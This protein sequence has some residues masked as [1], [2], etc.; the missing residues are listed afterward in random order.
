[1]FY[2]VNSVVT[3][4]VKVCT[5]LE[6]ACR[7]TRALEIGTPFRGRVKVV[8]ISDGRDILDSFVTRNRAAGV[9]SLI[10]TTVINCTQS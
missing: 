9:E 10:Y 7:T 8:G 3:C 4:W 6:M 1:M 2:H 5:L